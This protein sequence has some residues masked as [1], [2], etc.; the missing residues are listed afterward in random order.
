MR[1]RRLLALLSAVALVL[2]ACAEPEVVPDTP[3]DTPP[4]EPVDEVEEPPDEPVPEPDVAGDLSVVITWTGSEFE[5]FQAVIG[6]FEDAYPDV[7]VDIIQVPFGELN[8]QLTAQFAAGT[9]PD[10]T[11]ALP[12][13][14]RLFASQGF[15]MPLDDIW[16]EWMAEGAYTESLR[17]IASFEGTPYSTWFKANVN[18]LIWYT[19]AQLEELGVAVPETWE[20]FIE[21]L[22]TIQAAGEEP[23][24]VGGADLWVLTQ[25]WD[26]ILARVGGAEAFNGLIDG[27]V[28]WDDPRVVESFEVFGDFIEAYFPGDALDR[29]FVEATC[30]RVDGLAA[31]QNQGAFINLIARGECNPD[32]V[33]GDDYTFFLMPKYDEA[34]PEVQFVSGDL[35][36]AAADTPNPEAALALIRYLGSAEAQAVWA[37]R[38]G[39][40][41]PN[42]H[43]PLDVYPDVN[44]VLAAELWPRSPDVIAVYDLD[45]F[46]GGE[47]QTILREALQNFVRD[48][49]VDRIVSTMVEVDQRVRG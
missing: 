12:G 40:V 35:F 46:I 18:A 22:D 29:G 21:G 33:P 32:L 19:P 28:G 44:D 7:N 10:V 49:D 47:I 48:R 27:T 17:Q 11:V 13:I 6:G 5:A 41:A 25:W 34:M 36:A 31:Y 15:L 4:P 39:F 9:P 30:A 24:A 2:V 43:V 20:E 14:I 42:A 26:P 1:T 16:D 37:E 38:G 3:P 45:D 8:A 23:F